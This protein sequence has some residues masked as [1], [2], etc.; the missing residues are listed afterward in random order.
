M[1]RLRTFLLGTARVAAALA[2]CLLPLL[3]GCEKPLAADDL[4]SAVAAVDH[5]DWSEAERLLRRCLREEQAP[6]RRWTAWRL[7]LQVANLAG[8][9]SKT[10]LA[11]LD[12]MLEEFA[13]DDARA[14]DILLQMA[15]LNEATHRYARAVDV[16]SSFVGLA[17]LPPEEL[18]RGYSG[19]AIN[20]MKQRLFESAEETLQQC[21][22]LPVPYKAK[23]PCMFELAD[24]RSTQER[25]QEA[26][27]YS[28]EILDFLP[29]NELRGLAGFLLA[30]A[31][32]QL[33]RNQ[34]ALN[35]FEETREFFPNDAVVDNRIA[36]L[37]K[38]LNKRS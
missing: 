18:V 12:A 20:Q 8:E 9:E 2:L 38:K 4:S 29:G 27:D 26:A 37:R 3:S 15:A 11:Y 23:L 21:L 32:E 6:D 34:E 10:S 31:L 33:G 24:L 14:R 1:R 25:W 7:L 28:Q 5:R 22:G 30:D 13:D 17:G 35:R 36:Q 19:L 16:W